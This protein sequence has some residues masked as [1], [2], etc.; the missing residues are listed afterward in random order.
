MPYA[1]GLPRNI[2]QCLEDYDI[3]LY[4]GRTITQIKGKDRLECVTVQKV[5]QQLT[6]V[7][8]TEQ[9]ISCDT[10]I[11]S[12]GL[13]PENELSKE[14][15]INID[16]LTQGPLV[17]AY[18]QTSV[19]GIFAAGNVLHVHDLVDDVS[20]EAEKLA[21]AVSQYLKYGVLPVCMTEV[22]AGNGIAQ[23]V[24]QRVCLQT[25]TVLSVRVK[26]PVQNGRL[27]VLK[28]GAVLV[29]KQ[30]RQLL[31]AVMEQ[32]RIPKDLFFG[33]EGRL[34]VLVQTGE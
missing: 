13:L 11:L 25:E 19:P 3:P 14:A 32:I 12:V 30:Y 33:R 28:E 29:Q 27:L 15:G 23:A 26:Y 31:P 4:L 21:D 22:F 18:F 24:P 8:G 1:N 16:P 5:D 9:E 6:P 2:R 7:P 34:E 20:D 17:D 10:L